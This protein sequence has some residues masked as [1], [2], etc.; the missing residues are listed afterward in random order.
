M[1]KKAMIK[2]S[3]DIICSPLTA[4]DVF[5]TLYLKRLEL[6]DFQS[7]KGVLIETTQ[8]LEKELDQFCSILTEDRAP[9][10]QRIE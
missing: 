10:S 9:K 5:L 7:C 4:F 2:S 6:S 3:D 1:T 8:K